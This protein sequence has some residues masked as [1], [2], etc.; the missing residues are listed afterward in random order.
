MGARA[1]RLWIKRSGTGLATRRSQRPIKLIS[2][3][4]ELERRVFSVAI[5]VGS[6]ESLHDAAQHN[7][8]HL[9]PRHWQG[10][11]YA[12]HEA[13]LFSLNTSPDELAVL[14]HILHRQQ[15]RI[16][17]LHLLLFCI[18]HLHILHLLLLV[19]CRHLSL[20]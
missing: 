12:E 6:V 14:S 16:F 9:P 5:S 4:D 13:S 2:F 3:S 20:L 11:Q 15:V 19:C 10:A 18:L 7:R 17:L 1:R 8:V